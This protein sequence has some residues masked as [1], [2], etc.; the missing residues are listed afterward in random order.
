MK[1]SQR[2]DLVQPD[3]PAGAQATPH[4]DG[5]ALLPSDPLAE[6][7]DQARSALFE[8]LEKRSLDP[9]LTEEQ[10]R[11]SVTAE[12]QRLMAAGDTPLTAEERERIAGEITRD[13][14]GHGPIERFLDDQ[15]VTEIMVNGTG[16]I[17]IER[18]G[19]L[20]A[21][22]SHFSS[23]EHLRHVIERIVARVG[24]RIDESSPMVDA[25]LPDGS[26]VNA[27]IPP[28]AIDGPSLTIRKFSAD[29]YRVEDLVR[30]ETM[31]IEVAA[32]LKAAVHGK[33]NLL[34]T[35]GT[36]TG[37]TTL[38]NVLSSFIP[39]TERVVT[40][41]DAAELQLPLRNLVRLESRP[42]NIEGRGRVAIR[43]LVRNALRMR[44]DR[45][46]VGEV[47]GA[48]ALDMLQAMNTG[49]EGS[50]STLH[51]NS[52]R[53]ALSRLETMV[54]MAGL[55][56]PMN[57]VRDYISSALT[58][59][60]HLSRMRDGT[61]R[62]THITEIVGM[63]GD[64]VTMQDIFKFRHDGLDDAGRVKGRLEATGIR[65]KFS[66]HLTDRG[67]ALPAEMFIRAAEPG[68]RQ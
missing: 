52:P 46:V 44:P 11:A 5:P 10:L 43:D 59:I 22:E 28:L 58:L 60:A 18:S 30:F 67:I 26:R 65:P 57:A 40:I 45:I 37:K 7:K 27:I 16:E 47:R 56:I 68:N 15:E 41:E 33:L 51:A 53:D 14:V 64:V 29:P 20:E 17:F 38:L 4:G 49:H 23:E 42:P 25:R 24:R 21:T 32:L 55:E 3:R 66:E 12:L 8:K 50:M 6:F 35:G 36:G 13:L 19:R 39:P 63:E 61:R 62:I 1:L 9:S 34:V 54:L 2:L 48:E 31:T